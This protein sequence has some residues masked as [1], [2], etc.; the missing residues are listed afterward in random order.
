MVGSRVDVASTP[1]DATQASHLWSSQGGGNYSIQP[2]PPV[3][4]DGS[5]SSGSS[6]EP[7]PTPGRGCRITIHLKDEHKEYLKASR[8]REV[9]KTHS[10]FVNFPIRVEGEVVNTVQAIW[11]Q[12]PGDVSQEDYASFYKFMTGS[13]DEPTYRLHFRA[14]SPIDLKVKQRGC[15][16]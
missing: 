15:R 2:L 3:G 12:P 6:S 10:N 1:A 9:I 13:Y 8:L 14:D 16:T 11:T 5:S 7:N 4:S